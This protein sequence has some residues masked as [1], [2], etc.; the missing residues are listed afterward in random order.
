MKKYISIM[1]GIFFVLLILWNRL[2]R[3]RLPREIFIDYNE[4]IITIYFILFFISLYIVIFS[5]R[6]ILT[7]HATYKILNNLLIKFPLLEKIFRIGAEWIINIILQGPKNFYAFLYKRMLIRP[8]IDK[9]CKYIDTLG[10]NEQPMYIYIILVIKYSVIFYVCG[11]F[12]IDVFILNYFETFYKSTILL[13]LPLIMDLMLFIIYDL[14][15]KNKEI[16]RT[17]INFVPNIYRDGFNM[18]LN[19]YNKDNPL[20]QFL[21]HESM[22]DNF[23]AIMNYHYKMWFAYVYACMTIDNLYNKDKKIKPYINIVIYSIYSMGWVYIIIKI[24]FITFL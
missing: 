19:I 7:I 12:L 8:I 24:F 13:L 17:W 18:R 21:D 23:L 2:I 15:K 9:I 11:R 5:L 6:E 22:N 3:H 10:V 20:F 14:A 16:I 1:F 4:T